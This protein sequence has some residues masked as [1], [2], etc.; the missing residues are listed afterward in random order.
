MGPPRPRGTEK[1]KHAVEVKAKKPKKQPKER[2]QDHALK[3]EE[4]PQ[5]LQQLLLSVFK[6]SFDERLRTDLQPLL[7]EI[8]GH[9]FNRDFEAAFGKDEYLE[10]YAARWSP[11]RVL[12]FLQVFWD[13]REHILPSVAFEDS[14]TGTE[15]G[16]QNK[17][18]CLGGGGGAELVAWGGFMNAMQADERYVGKVRSLEVVTIDIANWTSVIE[19]LYSTLTTAPPISKYAST[20]AQA[21]NVRLMDPETF[22][23]KPYQLDILNTD[24]G[25]LGPLLQDATLLTIM[26]TLNELYST[27]LSLTQK[28]LLQLTAAVKSG[29]LLL[30]GDSPGSYS[31]VKMELEGAGEKEQ[32]EGK[33]KQYPMQWLL[34]RTLLRLGPKGEDSQWKKI[35]EEES[36]WYRMREELRYPI[37]LEN[38]RFQ[39]HLYRRL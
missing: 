8:K 3:R 24:F 31:T 17:V 16:E 7:Q 25:V 20:A 1:N 38:M 10:A 18:V 37:E 22:K 2:S 35:E 14:N 13:V 30:V 33:A 32:S 5:E 9:L 29:T 27:S 12:G 39:L 26:F 4:I 23:V 19:T 11:S 34:D 36:R 21:A 15:H 28:F 6:N